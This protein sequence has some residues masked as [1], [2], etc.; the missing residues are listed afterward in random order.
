MLR[1][2]QRV[3][4]LRAETLPLSEGITLP[5]CARRWK[6]SALNDPLRTAVEFGLAI[7]VR[8]E[9]LSKAT[10][11]ATATAAAAA[12]VTASGRSNAG[13]RSRGKRGKG[14]P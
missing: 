12:A 10:T 2:A 14:R 5:D 13:F 6:V 9:G 1:R 8:S 3:P 7:A 11:M 4:S